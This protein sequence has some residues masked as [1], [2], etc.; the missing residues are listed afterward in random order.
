[1]SEKRGQFGLVGVAVVFVIA[2]LAVAVSRGSSSETPEDVSVVPNEQVATTS[3]PTTQPVEVSTTGPAVFRLEP[4]LEDADLLCPRGDIVWVR[5]N[6]GPRVVATYQGE[7]SVHLSEAGN[8]AALVTCETLGRSRIIFEP[9]DPGNPNARRGELVDDFVDVAY[10]QSF[11]WAGDNFIGVVEDEGRHPGPWVWTNVQY[12]PCTELVDVID[13]VSPRVV[14]SQRWTSN[15]EG[16][17]DD[18][19]GASFDVSVE[20]ASASGDALGNPIAVPLSVLGD[21]PNTPRISRWVTGHETVEELSDGTR[22]VTWRIPRGAEVVTLQVTTISD[23][24]IAAEVHLAHAAV[25]EPVETLQ[26]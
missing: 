24:A 20:P 13:G 14:D 2:I 11:R 25:L 4:Y 22:R 7:V 5:E 8:F 12:N 16:W 15:G 6:A 17:V 23:D 19:N 18:R 3:S 21:R 9:H 1:M 10:R 26:G